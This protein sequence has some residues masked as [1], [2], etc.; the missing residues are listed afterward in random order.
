MSALTCLLTSHS[1]VGWTT[2]REEE[3]AMTIAQIHKE[4]AKEA[5]RGPVTSSS[6]N[7][8]NSSHSFRQNKPSIDKDGFVEVV[9]PAGGGFN[10]SQSLGNFKRH[11]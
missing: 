7:R 3:S 6:M 11:T 4:A 2:R 8:S 1:S 10:R 9:G 5:R